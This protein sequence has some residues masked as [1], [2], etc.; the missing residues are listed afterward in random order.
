MQNIRLDLYACIYVGYESKEEAK[1][2][3]LGVGGNERVKEYKDMFQES[4]G[5]DQCGSGGREKQEGVAA[6]KNKVFMYENIT[7][8]P[9]CMLSK[10]TMSIILKMLG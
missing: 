3:G 4:K 9:I 2:I 7:T 10:S 5:K 8:R 6:N 1:R